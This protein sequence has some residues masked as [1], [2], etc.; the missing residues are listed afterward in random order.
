[1]IRSKHHFEWQK[2]EVEIQEKHANNGEAL[3]KIELKF[4]QIF[5]KE[6]SRWF[7][8]F[9]SEKEGFSSLFIPW[10]YNINK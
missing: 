10:G 3:S 7:S 5:A 4:E 1:M 2:K 9:F 8:L 6:F